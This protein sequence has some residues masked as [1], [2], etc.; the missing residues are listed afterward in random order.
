ME[1]LEHKQLA[2]LLRQARTGNT[3]AFKAIYEHT[4]P[5]QYLQISQIVSDPKEAED[6]LQETYLLLYQN[7]DKIDPP[8]A[9]V[10]YLNRL[11]YYISKNIQ[12]SA[13]RRHLRM[14]NIEMMDTYFPGGM[15][16]P[17]KDIE[18]KDTRRSVRNTLQ[19]LEERERMVLIMHYYQHLGIK[20]IS[21][22]LD[23][24]PATVKRIHQSA[25][26][27]LK[28]LL[29]KQGVFGWTALAPVLYDI[30]DEQANSYMP[31][32]LE[33]RPETNSAPAVSAAS[34]PAAAGA[35]SGTA[36]AAVKGVLCSGLLGMSL[37][38][39]FLLGMPQ[40]G[41]IEVTEHSTAKTAS[42]RFDLKNAPSAERITALSPDGRPIPLSKSGENIWN[43]AVEANGT[44]SFTV[45]D[46]LH[47]ASTKKV[48]VNSI[49]DQPPAAEIVSASEKITVVK[50][51]DN[52]A[53]IDE[54]SLWCEGTER[55]PIHPKRY[56]KE[57][58]EAVFELP[59]ED[60]TL[61]FSDNA[62][63]QSSSVIH[64]R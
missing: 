1:K 52:K 56:D 23:I 60:V 30:L 58:G 25:K 4:A 63:N 13:N 29:D 9:L 46:G 15:P 43:A 19:C 36:G 45:E 18:E 40:I 44:Y 55:I 6:A 20:Q 50:F 35:L 34:M 5:V 33:I 62:G 53:G 37:T 22:S 38:T 11:S 21:Y 10:A 8:T 28:L 64:C 51:T 42:V 49:D 39:G 16:S 54:D 24:S 61:Y 41:N 17:S 3:E 47:R 7:L 31:Q 57:T 14:T 27:H 48:T 2:Q 26:K 59:R 12:R 32:K